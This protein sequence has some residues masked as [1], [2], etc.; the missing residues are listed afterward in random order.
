LTFAFVVFGLAAA[1]PARAQD[2]HQSFYQ[3]VTSNGF[4]VVNY[5]TED[6]ARRTDAYLEHPFRYWDDNIAQTQTRD[7]CYDTYFG[8]RVGGSATWLTELP[9]N[10]AA[11]IPGTGVI[12]VEQT[13]Q[14]LT[15]RHHVFAPFGPDYPL[16]V[17]AL[18]VENET[19]NPSAAVS[20]FSIHNFHLGS[21]RPDPGT[22]GERI[23]W[24]GTSYTE[25]GAGG[26]AVVYRP[27]PAP[28]HYACSPNNPYP[29]VQA[30]QDL[31]DTA[32]SGVMDDAVAG[33]Q[34]DATPMQPNE[35][36]WAAVVIGHNVFANDAEVKT[37]ISTYV[38]GKDPQ[39]L[40]T[41]ETDQW[42]AWITGAPAALTA[43][44]Q[45]LWVQS[46]VILRMGQVREPGGPYGQILASL[47]PGNWNIAW[48]R[49]MSYAIVGLARSGHPQEGWDALEFMLNADSGYY[50]SYVGYPYQISITRYFG[51]GTEE[52]DSNADGPNIE[53]DG[54][55][56]FLWAL[57]EVVMRLRTA[58][59]ATYWPVIRDEIADV[60]VA[61]QDPATG[62]IAA[63]S[64]I[65]EVHWNGRQKRYTYT[66][67][68]AA[69]GLCAAAE[70]AELSGDQARADNYRQTSQ[71]IR[72]ALILHSVDSNG[73]LAQSYEELIGN[74]GYLDAAVV[75][76]L[77]W[78]MLDPAGPVAQAT[79]DAIV[80][81][82]RPPSGRGFFRNDD[83][84]WY[85]S[86]EW[87]FVDLRSALAFS[88]GGRQAVT[89]DLK[90]WITD[91]AAFNYNLIAE[92][93]DENNADYRGEVPM[94]GFGA[95]AYIILQDRLLQ[96]QPTQPPCGTYA[97]GPD[98]GVDPDARPPTDGFVPQWDAGPGN[99]KNGGCDCRAVPVRR[100]FPLWIVL[101]SLLAL[102]CFRR[103]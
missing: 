51:N 77:N 30:G 84:G 55:G 36:A 15:V 98:A 71:S 94:V 64:S 28:S 1:Q 59:V 24:D 85:D 68:A 7:L 61:L 96:P 11:Y 86:Q 9:I 81:N 83:G 26:A 14:G 63:D 60:L 74:S 39:I 54:F 93:H 40:L 56:L 75:E 31:T 100:S 16:A 102:A 92:L 90:S 8:V 53:F 89:D 10:S 67:L 5:N 91:M 13:Y 66:S 79:L 19:A 47:P 62:L 3:L 99:G 70:I 27:V 73:V 46:E 58:P 4:V 101:V 72:E 65:W 35:S 42:A 20:I 49:D 87:V 78:G 43:A 22:D 76:G 103:R 33:F 97:G 50:E 37:A 34:W 21:G 57:S 82:L 12:R 2:P 44:E 41:D 32:D 45:A 29:A 23:Q 52:S 17:M 69:R 25:T 38:S 88:L 95:G 80:S 18:Q 48:V 6:T